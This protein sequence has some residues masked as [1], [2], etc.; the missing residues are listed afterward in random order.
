MT[1]IDLTSSSGFKETKH[2]QI[3]GIGP[4]PLP[5]ALPLFAGALGGLGIV[6]RWRKRRTGAP[7]SD[8]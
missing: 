7:P 2:F 3:S 5:A 1:E 4:V 8:R 6:G